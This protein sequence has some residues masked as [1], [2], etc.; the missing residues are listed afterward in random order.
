VA[1]LTIQRSLHLSVSGLEWAVS[2]YL[3]TLGL[4]GSGG[5]LIASGFNAMA[6]RLGSTGRFAGR[7]DTGAGRRRVRHDDVAGQ[8]L[9]LTQRAGRTFD[10]S[11]AWLTESLTQLLLEPSP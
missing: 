9:Q 11:E 4:A 2:S 3:L 5:V 8:R 10:D 6:Q 1:I 7:H